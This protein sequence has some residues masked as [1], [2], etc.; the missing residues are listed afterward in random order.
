MLWKP[1]INRNRD[2]VLRREDDRTSLIKQF[3]SNQERVLSYEIV[4]TDVWTVDVEGSILLTESDLN[5]GEL[6]FKIGKLSGNLYCQCKHFK[7]SVV[8][9][10]MGGE[11]VFVPDET[12]QAP[13]PGTNNGNT[14]SEDDSYGM[15]MLCANPTKQK[16]LKKLES[17]VAEVIRYDYDFDWEKIIKDMISKVKSERAKI[18][19]YSLRMSVRADSKRGFQCDF[20]VCDVNKESLIDLTPIHKTIYMMFILNKEGY[21]VDDI[22]TEF[23][24]TARKIY[25]QLSDRVQ[26]DDNGI[27]GILLSAPTLRTYLTEIRNALK[28]IISNSEVIERFAIEGYREQNYKVEIATNEI[29]D[30]IHET[31]G[32]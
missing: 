11:I 27:M 32:V 20:Y 31:F 15:E 28:K 1:N 2:G 3:F 18:N 5:D 26:D 12:E 23:T 29:R 25:S 17:V 4:D 30:Q 22:N 19:D 21:I 24:Y 8:P 13:T 16:T 10:E 7:P 14:N 6:F 9:L